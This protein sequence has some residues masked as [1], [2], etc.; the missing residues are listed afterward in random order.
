MSYNQHNGYWGHVKGGH[1]VLD[2]NFILGPTEVLIWNPC[3]S[4]LPIVWTEFQIRAHTSDPYPSRLQMQSGF[5][6][7]HLHRLC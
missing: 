1:A 4:G 3:A 6:R 5:E 2:K 7:V